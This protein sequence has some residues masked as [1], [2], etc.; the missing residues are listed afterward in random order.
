MVQHTRLVLIG[1]T[2]SRWPYP[3]SRV[4]ILLRLG[5]KS[6]LAG[7]QSGLRVKAD[8][9]LVNYLGNPCRTLPGTSGDIL[10]N[11]TNRE[12]PAPNIGCRL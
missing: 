8:L 2:R 3:R 4:K 11:E 5:L 7:L 12:M 10:C 1:L 6:G 9:V